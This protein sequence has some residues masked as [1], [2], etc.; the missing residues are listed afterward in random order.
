MGRATARASAGSEPGWPPCAW[1]HSS[2][3]AALAMAGAL[4]ATFT[5][6][7]WPWD[8]LRRFSAT[9]AGCGPSAL[10]CARVR[11]QTL[12]T[13]KDGSS[14]AMPLKARRAPSRSL[15]SSSSATCRSSSDSE[16]PESRLSSSPP[17]AGSCK[18]S[19]CE[20][21]MQPNLSLLGTSVSNSSVWCC[22][23]TVATLAFSWLLPS[24]TKANV[25]RSGGKDFSCTPSAWIASRMISAIC[26]SGR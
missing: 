18:S 21:E 13:R 22:R 4:M 26:S 2:A 1:T 11:S 10:T 5:G 8:A 20:R 23:P 24:T 3:A 25:R 6:I 14:S 15:V 7:A 9:T 12:N 17:E 16:L 19:K